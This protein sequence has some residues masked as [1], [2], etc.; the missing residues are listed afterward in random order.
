VNQQ[1]NLYQPIF[2]RQKKVFSAIAMLQVCGIFLV[3]FASIYLYGQTKL[4]PLQE[5]SIQVRADIAKMNA[6]LSKMENS[7]AAVSP[8]KL[9][10]NE[11]ARLSAELQKRQQI[12]DMLESQTLGNTAGLSSFMTAFARQHVQGM[13]LTKIT[14]SNGGR[15]LGLQGKTLTSEL[16]PQYLTRLAGE[17]VLNGMSFNVLNLSRPVD[18]ANP[19][20]FSVSTK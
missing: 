9:V 4:Q 8:S 15:N 17:D 7:A 13:W 19:L 11:I 6:Q 20:E 18:P 3:V 16:L 2:R 1:I 5:Q 10:E 12:K 14:V